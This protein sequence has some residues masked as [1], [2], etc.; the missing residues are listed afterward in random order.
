MEIQPGYKK[1]S[2]LDTYTFKKILGSGGFADTWLATNEK[3]EKFA[4]KVLKNIDSHYMEEINNLKHISKYCKEHA[5]CYIDNFT[6]NA[7]YN[8]D[9]VQE[10]YPMYNCI[11]MNYIEGYDIYNNSYSNDTLL[12]RNK[13]D[14]IIFDLIL[15][16]NL[17]HSLNIAHQ[18]I[19]S[20]NIMYDSIENT[21]KYIDWGNSCLITSCE[22]EG[23]CDEPCGYTGTLIFSS[24]EKLKLYKNSVFLPSHFIDNILHDIWSL[25][26]VLL[27]WYT[28]INVTTHTY[29]QK[30]E[31]L[32]N[33]TQFN[34]LA[35]R[36]IPL[37]LEEDP[38]QRASNWKPIVTV[39]QSYKNN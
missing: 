3:D 26:L 38:K 34:K 32:I 4:I 39:L 1:K 24:P 25:G 13:S 16:L 30:L 9:G 7:I 17:L 22:K 6:I 23:K 20:L 5:V 2:E 29:K 10:K 36:I 14:K 8:I 31:L 33:N 28:V 27:S 12:E 18:D 11:V 15:G 37:L 21:Y 19:K 35:Q